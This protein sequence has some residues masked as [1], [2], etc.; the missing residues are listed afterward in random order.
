[1]V[2]WIVVIIVI[3]VVVFIWWVGMLKRL[4]W[5]RSYWVGYVEWKFSDV[6]RVVSRISCRIRVVSVKKVKF[7]IIGG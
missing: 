6:G 4:V 5:R 1:M 7:I 3:K 2:W